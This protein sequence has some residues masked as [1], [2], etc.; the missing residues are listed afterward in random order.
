MR[1]PVAV[2]GLLQLRAVQQRQLGRRPEQRRRR[3]VWQAGQVPRPLAVGALR[4]LRHQEQRELRTGATIA[5]RTAHPCGES[6]QE[7]ASR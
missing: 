5:G 2:E 6:S 7:R 1:A 3:L 4:P